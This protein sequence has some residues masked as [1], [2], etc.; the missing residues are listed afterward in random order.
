MEEMKKKE[1]NHRDT[2]AQRH[3]EEGGRF[4]VED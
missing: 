4:S 3:G 1:G 2:E